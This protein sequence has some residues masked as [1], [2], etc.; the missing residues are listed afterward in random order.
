MG[1]IHGTAK[2][3]VA[4]GKLVQFLATANECVHS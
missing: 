4:C 2:N 1:K 3:F